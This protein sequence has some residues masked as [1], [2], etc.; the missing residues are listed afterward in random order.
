MFFFFK[1][2]RIS[3]EIDWYHYQGASPAPTCPAS[4]ND[5]DPYELSV[6][7]EPSVGGGAKINYLIIT[8]DSLLLKSIT[9]L[10]CIDLLLLGKVSPPVV[11]SIIIFY[12]SELYSTNCG[13]LYNYQ[14]AKNENLFISVNLH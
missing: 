4:N 13:C 2:V 9:V 5:K 11:L 8:N 14:R 6:K 10:H 7:S 3:P 12:C 1:W